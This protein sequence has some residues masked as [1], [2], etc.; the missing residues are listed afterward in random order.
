MTE[1]IFVS[2]PSTARTPTPQGHDGSTTPS[3]Q[4]VGRGATPYR[5]RQLQ[6]L[7]LLATLLPFI[8]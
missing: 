6:V 8:Y 3:Q 1:A 7:K 5:R 2:F 4:A